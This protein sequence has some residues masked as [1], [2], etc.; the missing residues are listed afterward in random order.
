M[1]DEEHD[2]SFKQQER[3]RYHAR[4]VAL[5]R[6]V[7]EK[8]PAIL[9]TATPSLETVQAA[10]AGRAK[11][12]LLSER[13]TRIEMPTVKMI[14][15]GRAYLSDGLSSPLSGGDSKSNGRR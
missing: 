2:S 1:I 9:G 11:T 4:S 6:A 10:R 15:L 8:I 14:D 7:S 13:A 3:V 12:L 5:H